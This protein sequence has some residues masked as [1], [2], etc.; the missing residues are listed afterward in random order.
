MVGAALWLVP[1]VFAIE[2]TS[3]PFFAPVVS[4]LTSTNHPGIATGI[5]FGSVILLAL[6]GAYIFNFVIGGAPKQAAKRAE[7]TPERAPA[8]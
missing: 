6:T 7:S 3:Q 8:H 4:A 2:V 5:L 1:Q